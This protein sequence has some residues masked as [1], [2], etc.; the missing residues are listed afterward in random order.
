MKTQKKMKK[1]KKSKKRGGT[2]KRKYT[3]KV[4]FDDED[5]YVY[6]IPPKIRICANNIDN[7]TFPCKLVDNYID[8]E[9]IF[10][11]MQ[12]LNEFLQSNKYYTFVNNNIYKA[13]MKTCRKP[14]T[15]SVE[16]IN[17][18]L[19]LLRDDEFPCK[20]KNRVFENKD[21]MIELMDLIKQRTTRQL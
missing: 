9:I 7:I 6:E 13:H 15:Y 5:D 14:I 12:E 20:F 10:F 8:E 1:S 3:K 16:S 18:Y 2:R 21:E 4:L 19:S 17:D 11:S